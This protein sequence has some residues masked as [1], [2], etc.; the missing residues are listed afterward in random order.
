MRSASLKAGTTTERNTSSGMDEKG[1]KLLRPHAAGRHDRP[2][3][4]QEPRNQPQ[5]GDLSAQP[6]PR[7]RLPP[8]PERFQ[9]QAELGHKDAPPV[10]TQERPRHVLGDY[11]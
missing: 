9:R 10:A 6:R 1:L 11:G 7:R 8:V 5:S 3:L 4:L 2:A